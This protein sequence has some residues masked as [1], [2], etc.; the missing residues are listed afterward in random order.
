MSTMALPLAK[1]PPP[2][3]LGRAKLGLQSLN[4]FMA[5]MQAGIGP[6]LGVFLQQKGWTSGLIG[7]V[8]TLGGHGR[9]DHDRAGRCVHRPH[10]PQAA[11][12]DP[13]PRSTIGQRADSKAT[14][15]VAGR[16]AR[17]RGSGH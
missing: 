3:G 14:A 4:F 7:T 1:A 10:H 2:D 11:G 9:D 6:F 8:M 15:R 13:S 17:P 5:D 12:R 16:R